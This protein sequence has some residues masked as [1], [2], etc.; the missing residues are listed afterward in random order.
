MLFFIQDLGSSLMFY[1]GFL[2]VLYV[3]TNRFSFVAIGLALFAAGSWVLY[4]ARP[5][6]THRVDAWLHPFGAL[7]DAG[8]RQLPDRAVGLRAGRRR[9]LRAAASG[10]RV[11]K[12][13]GSPLLPAAQTDLIY[14]VIVNE[15][16]LIGACAVLCTYLL[17][18]ERGFKIATL[19]R[20]SFSKLL[21]TGP[22]RGLRAAGLR[23]RRRRHARHPAHRRDAALHLLRRLVDP[24][25]LRAAGPAAADLRPRAARG[26]RAAMNAPIARL[27]VVVVRPLR[28][29]SSASPRAGRCST[30]M[31]C[32]TT[33]RTTAS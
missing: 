24:G 12:V 22:D 14:S 16:G 31:R 27:F 26:D 11:L 33:P 3:A 5:T 4:H 18:V 28:R 25:Q 8:R 13:G 19:A 1:G 2:A 17:A 15:L 30:P 23:H 6:I 7:Y 20:D 9:P 21:A 10:R 29:C 32:A